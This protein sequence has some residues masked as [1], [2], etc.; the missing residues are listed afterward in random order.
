VLPGCEF[1]IVHGN[2]GWVDP[3]EAVSEVIYISIAICG[4]SGLR[5]NFG[6]RIFYQNAYGN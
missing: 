3:V 6:L 5:K 4:A 1:I 2:D